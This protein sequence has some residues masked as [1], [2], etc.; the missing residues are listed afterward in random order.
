MNNTFIMKYIPMNT[1]IHSLDPR[2]KLVFAIIYLLSIF[3]SRT[4][5]KFLFLILILI[6]ITYLAKIKFKYLFSGIKLILFLLIFTSLIHIV[7]N[8]QGEILFS[9]LNFKIYYGAVISIILIAIRFFLVV[10]LMTILTI[11]T[12]PKEVTLAIEKSLNF[13]NIFSIHI[14]SFALLISICIRF[15][16]TLSEETQR[17]KNAQVSRGAKLNAKGFINKVKNFIPILVP[18]FVSALKRADELATAMEIRGYD[19]DKKRTRYKKLKY[20]KKDFIAY[21]FTGLI[22]VIMYVLK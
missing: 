14:S 12:S 1:Y 16:P 15:I 4:F 18:V 11:T 8:R 17:I 22:I 7:F 21:M 3:L 6:L 13:L 2:V 9:F 19:P 20:N 10:S 5:L